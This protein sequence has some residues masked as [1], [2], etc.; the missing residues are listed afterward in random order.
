M[1][2]LIR[3]K[4]LHQVLLVSDAAP[5]AG[6]P[7]GEYE[8][9]H[10]PV[11]VENGT[12]RLADGTIAGA[13]ALLDSGVRNL[14]SEV[15]LPLEKALMPATLTAA[16]SVNLGN[17]GQL[18]PGYDADLVVL[19]HDLQPEMTLVEGELLWSQADLK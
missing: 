7:E 10:K 11:F 3:V 6:L 5:L 15:G 17:K 13:H 14:V 19:D 1:G 18:R 9:E 2:I 16:T 8:W 12:C 4:G